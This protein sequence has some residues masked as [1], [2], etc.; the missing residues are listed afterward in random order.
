M[1]AGIYHEEICLKDSLFFKVFFSSKMILLAFPLLFFPS[2][3]I[4]LI[5]LCKR[6]ARICIRERQKI[7]FGLV[8]R[9]FIFFYVPSGKFLSPQ[10]LI[11]RCL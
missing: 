7:L 9:A 1:I 10:L 8:C 5:C 11:L 6:A 3:Y 4:P 2:S